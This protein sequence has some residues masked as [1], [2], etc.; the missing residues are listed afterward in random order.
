[1]YWREDE[2]GCPLGYNLMEPSCRVLL[3]AGRIK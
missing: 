1:V 3:H 2:N